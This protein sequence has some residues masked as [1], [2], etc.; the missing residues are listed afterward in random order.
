[1]V[2]LKSHCTVYFQAME[3]AEM[4]DRIHLRTTYYNYAKHLEVKGDYTEAIP[5]WVM[6]PYKAGS[7]L[8]YLHSPM[9]CLRL[10]YFGTMEFIHGWTT[11]IHSM[12]R[13]SDVR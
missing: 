3:T 10:T 8:V 2:I 12:L 1:M 7:A 9:T 6:Q 4:Y 5:K 13:I 11:I